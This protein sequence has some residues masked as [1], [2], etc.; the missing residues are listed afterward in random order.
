MITRDTIRL[1]P[2]G[3]DEAVITGSIT[4]DNIPVL[5]ENYVAKMNANNGFSGKRL[6]R[7]IASIPEVAHLKAYQ[8]G[9]NL[10]DPKELR[11]FLNDNPDYMTV[12][13]ID[14]G[15]SGHIIIK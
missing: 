15:A 3:A 6:F 9:Y 4:Q 13:N 12:R 2:L 14:T 1:T 7:R 10:D 8:D 5:D 11:R